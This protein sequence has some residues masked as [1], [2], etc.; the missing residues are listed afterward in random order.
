MKRSIIYVSMLA[1]LAI[2]ALAP[3][4]VGSARVTASTPTADTTAAALDKV[5]Q[6]GLNRGLPGIAL[7]VEHVGSTAVPGLS[8]KPVIDIMAP[9]RSLAE[10]TSAIAVAARHGYLHHP[11]RAEVMH[12]FCKPSPTVRTHRTGKD[13]A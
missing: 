2:V 9:V 5:L 8:A 13:H 4:S 12:W 6:S 10:S 7:R 11:Y 3:A 1:V